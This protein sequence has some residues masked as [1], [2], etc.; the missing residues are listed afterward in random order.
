MPLIL[1]QLHQATRVA[2]AGTQV[3]HISHL[4]DPREG[5]EE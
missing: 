2:E 1:P 3:E 5:P 4:L